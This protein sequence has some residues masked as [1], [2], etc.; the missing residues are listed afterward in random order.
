MTAVLPVGPT[1]PISGSMTIC[2]AFATFQFSCHEVPPRWLAVKLITGLP[3]VVG[4][5][6]VTG[7]VAVTLPPSFNAVNVYTV[8]TEGDSILEPTAATCPIPLSMVIVFAPE[9]LQLNS[10]G[11]PRT[12]LSEMPRMIQ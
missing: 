4:S 6:T 10:V 3:V 2:V 5:R 7:A 9:M 11:L 1:G 8:L 12:M